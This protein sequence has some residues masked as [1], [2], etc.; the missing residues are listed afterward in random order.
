MGS[1]IISTSDPKGPQP[2]RNSISSRQTEKKTSSPPPPPNEQ[3]DA[4][5]NCNPKSLKFWLVI[6]SVHLPFFLIALDRMIIATAIPAITNTFGSI[7]DIVWYVSSYMLTCAIFNPLFGKI[8]QLYD[9]KWTFLASIVVFEGGSALCGAAPTSVALIIGRA[10]AGIGAAGI[11]TGP[12]LGGTFTDSSSLTW[13][14]CFYINLPI[15]AF[16]FGVIFLFLNLS[17]ATKEKLSLFAQLK[18]LDPVGLLFFIPSMVCFILSLQWGGITYP[19]SEPKVVA[20]VVIFIVTFIAFVTVEFKMPDTA[21]APTRVVLNR[22]V[23]GSMLFVFFMSGAMM[24][25]IPYISIWFQAAQSQPAMQ[26]GIHTIPMVLSVVLFGIISAVF[27]QKIGYKWIAYQ[28]FYGIGLAIGA[29]SANM[30]AQ[31]V[32]PRSDI[33]LGISM[34]FFVQQLGG[35][36]FLAVGQNIFLKKLVKQLSG[37][38]GLDMT[39]IINTGATEQRNTVPA[40]EID[41]VISAY[42]HALT[43]VFFLSAAISVC[44]LF[45]SF[46]VEWRSIKKLDGQATKGVAADTEK[47]VEIEK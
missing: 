23:G 13:R 12:F 28:V 27:T 17:S 47:G 7:E 45:G 31:T 41:T 16:T 6:I 38:A 44:M 30:A 37:I 4:E 25:A 35:S 36:V 32:L 22:S 39:I 42:S 1:P 21:M 8:Y 10:I 9:T 24:N 33:A 5:K 18:P 40:N 15:G 11:T 20:L 29:Q 34:M 43:R 19:W 46:M 26:A 14:W 2:S 3:E